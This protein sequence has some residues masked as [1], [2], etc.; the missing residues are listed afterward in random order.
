L[1]N[2][3]PGQWKA[4]IVHTNMD[5]LKEFPEEARQ[6]SSQCERGNSAQVLIVGAGMVWHN[7]GEVTT[8]VADT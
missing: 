7:K 2:T 5:D 6:E 8:P 3:S 1:A 4:W